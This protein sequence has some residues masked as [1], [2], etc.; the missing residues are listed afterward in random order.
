MCPDRP[1]RDLSPPWRASG[2]GDR[3]ATLSIQYDVRVL[4]I[5]DVPSV[6]R[7]SWSTQRKAV[8]AGIGPT[9]GGG[10]PGSDPV[11]GGEIGWNTE[12]SGVGF[13]VVSDP[14]PRR[15]DLPE[16]HGEK[17]D[18]WTQRRTL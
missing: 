2:S 4:R 6:P 16:T 15:W 7:W 3:G 18:G 12:A 10:F 11:G 1:L 14:K 13:S 17:G 5:T 9:R 8:R